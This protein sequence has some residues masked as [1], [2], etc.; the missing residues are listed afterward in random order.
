MTERKKFSTGQ[1]FEEI[2]KRGEFYLDK[3]LQI[4]DFLDQCGKHNFLSRPRRFGKSLMLSVL[5]N[6]FTG[7]KELFEGLYIYDKLKFEKFPVLHLSFAG[8]SRHDDLKKY[9]Q[10]NGRIHIDDKELKIKDFDY[11]NIGVVLEEICERAGKPVV[12]LVDEYDKPILLHLKNIQKAEKVRNFFQDFYAPIKD[13]D[14]YIHFFM[15]TGL[16]KLMKMSIFSVLNNPK[17]ISFVGRHTD[18]I[19]YTQREVEDNFSKE[20]E[21][22]AKKQNR[23]VTQILQRM[24]EDY[25]GFNFGGEKL[26]NPWDINNFIENEE[27]G[28][29]WSDTGIPSTISDYIKDNAIDVQR[30]IDY[31]RDNSLIVSEMDLRVHNLQRLRPEVLFFNAGYLTIRNKDEQNHYY[32][33]FPNK[34]T[35]QVMLE[36]FLKLSLGKHYNLRDWKD[37]SQRITSGVFEQNADVIQKSVQDL[38]YRNCVGIPYDWHN[39]NP[40]GWLKSMVGVAIRMNNIYYMG[41]NQ[42]IIGRTDLHI[43]RGGA[44]YVL[45]FKVNK[46]VDEAIAQIEKDYVQSYHNSF[47]KIIKIGINWNKI[48]K[49]VDVLIK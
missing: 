4:Y 23:E 11:F 29:Y 46:N 31:E 25:N 26:Y 9:I 41:E 28:S 32:L 36:Y 5:K 49:K 14:R 40:E 24:K 6:I 19:G 38:I 43:L 48:S 45:E 34:E 18:L 15:L 42:N 2:K 47:E 3:T 17:D 22:I 39:K 27:F 7:K 1:D 21:A 44:V 30:I 10:Y 13:H 37:V 20:I 8:I 16:T 35:E 12:V 33:K